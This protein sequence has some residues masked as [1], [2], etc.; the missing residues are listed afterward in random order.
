MI[1]RLGQADHLFGTLTQSLAQLG[2]A[3]SV[4]NSDYEMSVYVHFWTGHLS[5]RKLSIHG[6]NVRKFSFNVRSQKYLGWACS[7]LKFWNAQ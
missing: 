5:S 2:I 3:K 6:K 1:L 7:E 4:L